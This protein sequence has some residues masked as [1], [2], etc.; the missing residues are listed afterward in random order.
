VG[1]A[2][3]DQKSLKELNRRS[4]L[5]IVAANALLLYGVA[6][7]ASLS[8]FDSA[9]LTKAAVRLFPVG[10]ACVV[11]TVLNGLLSSNTK[12][13]LVFWRRY[14]VLPGHRAFSEYAK[15]DSRI[16]L[17]QLEKLHGSPL[18]V[19]P[20]EQNRVWY[21]MYQTVQDKPAV[22]Q[23]H[24]DFLLLRDYSGLS[25]LFV[26]LLGVAAV[27][28]VPSRAALLAYFGFLILQ[29]MVVRIA[30]ATYGV[31][32]VTTVLAQKA[33]ARLPAKKTKPKRA[34]ME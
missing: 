29:Y 8:T 17:A 7:G 31:R 23:V 19:D 3:K 16:D 33:A 11:A 21:Q 30:A 18:P 20:V 13:K 12:E 14:H 34:K 9:A 6:Q 27:Y 24:R 10:F 28:A 25:V 32:F 4:I 2:L 5:A 1:A 15:T 22:L 26:A